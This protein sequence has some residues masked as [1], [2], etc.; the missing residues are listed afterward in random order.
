MTFNN[1]PVNYSFVYRLLFR[2]WPNTSETQSFTPQRPWLDKQDAFNQ[3][4]H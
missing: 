4:K 3:A 1:N 2:T